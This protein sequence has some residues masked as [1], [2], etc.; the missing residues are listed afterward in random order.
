MFNR[1]PVTPPPLH[2]Q[3]NNIDDD[4]AE[5]MRRLSL[6]DNNTI[7]DLTQRMSL[8]SLNDGQPTSSTPPT[9]MFASSSQPEAEAAGR[10][11][12]QP[13]LRDGSETCGRTCIPKSKKPKL[14][15]LDITAANQLNRRMVADGVSYVHG[16]NSDSFKGLAAFRALLP[17]EEIRQAD[18]FKEHALTSGERGNTYVPGQPISRG[19][20]L[21][22]VNRASES[23]HYSQLG[24]NGGS[25]P[26]LYGLDDQIR[27]FD[28]PN[29]QIGHPLSNGRISINHI[30]VI[31]VPP[32][33]VVI[34]RAALTE[35]GM[36]ELAARVHGF[37]QLGSTPSG[38]V[39]NEL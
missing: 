37:E 26:V 35:V 15:P 24:L 23:L 29:M 21:N 16:T 17:M 39:H 34:T 19:I 2:Y 32:D 12:S 1:R 3:E 20:S 22:Y 11:S 18:F 8:L 6:N 30:R 27:L 36:P 4:L 13:T 9:G 28:D 33:R 7:D 38:S 31:Y 14:P 25:Y 10:S 5:R